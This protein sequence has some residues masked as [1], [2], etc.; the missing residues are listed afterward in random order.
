MSIK[1]RLDKLE[2]ASPEKPFRAVI[3][4]NHDNKPMDEAIAR[5]ISNH[6]EDTDASKFIVVKWVG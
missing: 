2:L 5:H 3:V 4:I 6:P 1:T